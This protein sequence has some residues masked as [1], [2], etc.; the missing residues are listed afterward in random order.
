M[1]NQ[2]CICGNGLS[3]T[4]LSL[5][6]RLPKVIKKAIFVQLQSNA[7]VLTKVDPATVL[8][9]AWMTALINNVDKSLR[10]FPTV[11]I[12]N[13]TTDKADAVFEKYDDD[14]S[15]FVRESVRTFKG[16]IPVCPP[17]YKAKLESVRCNNNTGVY[18]VDI[19]G[20]LIGLSNNVDGSLYPI[21]VNAQSIYAGVA[22][23]TDKSTTGIMLSFEFPAS[24]DDASIW[25]ISSAAFTDFNLNFISGLL[26]AT[27]VASGIT[28]TGFTMKLSVRSS[29]ADQP[30]PVQ[31][32]L[33]S[34]FVLKNGGTT[35]TPTSVTETA[36]GTYVF[37]M[38]SQTS[39]SILSLTPTLAGFDF[40]TVALVPILI[41]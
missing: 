12:K 19:D 20:N 38:P 41:P 33:L 36:P 17:S 13:V 3:N 30:I 23:G 21:P 2:I 32:L 1:A 7:G 8:N 27:G 6:L 40:S 35:V 10:F 14:S 9:K 5:C 16:L 24:T 29:A 4:G 15:N 39:A 34:N 26:D 31:G 28:A 11:E 25:L 37:V 18:F 22:L